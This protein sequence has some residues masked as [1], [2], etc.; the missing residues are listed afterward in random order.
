MSENTFPD[1]ARVDA[2]DKVR[3]ATRYAAD[4]PLPRLA[5]AMTVPSPIVRGRLTAIETGAARDMPG[6][7]AVLTWRDFAGVASAG[8]L[9]GGGRA[10]QSHQPMLSDRLVHRGEPVALV[11]AET[12]ETATA[13]AALVRATCEAE[14]FTAALGETG[15][16]VTP[17]QQSY[18]VGDAEAAWTAAATRVDAAY[19]HPAQFQ[20]PM[21]L[22]ATVA[23][24]RDGVLSIHEGSQNAGAVK[25]GLAAALG[26]DPA[27]V[28]VDSAHLGGAFGQKNSMQL[29]TVLVARAAMLLG[30]PVKLVMPRA[31]LFHTASFRPASRHR[32]RL[33]ADAQGR[34]VAAVYEADMQNSRADTLRPTFSEI[35]SRLYDIPNYRSAE[36]LVRTDVQSPGYMRAPFEHPAAFAFESA[37]DELAHATGQDPLAFRLAHEATRDPVTGR[38]FSSRLLADC[39]RQGADRF[40]WARRT[41]QPGSMR[42]ENGMLVGWGVASGAYKAAMSPAIAR[43]R[44]RAN[45]TTRLSVSGHEMGQGMRNAILATL[46][47]HLSIDPARVDI[48]VGDTEAVPQHLTAGS[49]GTASAIPVVRQAALEVRQRLDELRG[50]RQ[51]RG[52]LHQMLARLR[53]PHIEVE[54][55]G[56]APGQPD[57]VFGRLQNGLPA[58]G[59]PEYP[60]FV[61]FS[62]AAHFVEVRVEPTTRR[63]RVPRV[64]STI[65]CGRVV[66]PRTAD[67]QVRGAVVWGIGA[68]LREAAEIDPR[69]GG[70]LNNDLAEYVVPVNADIGSIDV[71]FIDRPDLLLNQA[72]VKGLGEVAMVGVAAAIGNAIFHATGRRL[73]ELPMRMEHMV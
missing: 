55:R 73:R 26:L 30:R 33:G 19:S 13:A 28:R 49:W 39:L 64:V 57:A 43:L 59:G 42:D 34:M 14:P 11:V 20:N 9:L 68:A 22:I 62:F 65:D 31:Q 23:E 17:P 52:D 24:W 5:H 66:S 50:S 4:T 18:N 10:F 2:R 63:I 8:Y 54:V 53:R 70:V 36:R 35:T 46:M 29:Q 37:V 6:V 15:E 40:G 45:G 25:F 72:G 3:G 51:M 67:S 41:P 56:H 71:G 44:V 48:R 21:E 69:F 47:A 27:Q 16:E 12:L 1:R 38:P 60:D 61:S 32:V 7:L 58:A